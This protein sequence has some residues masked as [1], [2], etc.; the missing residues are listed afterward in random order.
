VAQPPAYD[1]QTDY[2]DFEAG[3]PTFVGL[4][5]K[6]DQEFAA[7]NAT[8]DATLVNLALIQRDDGALANQIVTNESLATD[9]SVGVSAARTWVTATAYVIN[10]TVWE[11]GVLYVCLIAHTS[12]VFATDLTALKWSLIIDLASEVPAATGILINT[13]TPVANVTTVLVEGD[14]GKAYDATSTAGNSLFTL[15]LISGLTSGSFYRIIIRKTVAANSV[16]VTSNVA[17]TINGAASQTFTDQYSS[18]MFYS[19]SGD[20][21]WKFIDFTRAAVANSINVAKQI[22]MF[23]LLT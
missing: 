11:A 3:T 14:N 19:R 13:V 15:P 22:T 21:D 6:L 8:F 23:K 17:D 4:G 7:I 18:G 1:P 9:V 5:T 10:D 16:I 20:T 2:S 12:G